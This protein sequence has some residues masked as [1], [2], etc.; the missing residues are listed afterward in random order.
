MPAHF[1]G[2]QIIAEETI[3]MEKVAIYI[4]LRLTLA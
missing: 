1:G 2:T 3:I 4:K